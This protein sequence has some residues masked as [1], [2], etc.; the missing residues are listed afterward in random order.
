MLEHPAVKE[1]AVIGV[2]DELRGAIVKAFVVLADNVAP[3]E[4]LTKEL[5]RWVKDRTAP[6]KFPRRIAY[7]D[8][9]P[10]T[11]NGKIRRAVLREWN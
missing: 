8:A 4:L 9:L 2:P 10:R 3:G 11:T 1:C 7:V 6:Y 5:Q